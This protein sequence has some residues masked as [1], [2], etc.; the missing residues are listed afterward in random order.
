MPMKASGL[1]SDA[2]VTEWDGGFSWI[3]HPGEGLE[4]SSHAL[5]DGE[6][7]WVVDPVDFDGLDDRLAEA[8]AVAGVVVLFDQH[9]RDAAAVA[10]R[11][12]VPVFV[13]AWLDR[14]AR[15]IDAPVERFDGQLGDTDY[16]AIRIPGLPLWQEAALF[17]GE[18]L[19]VGESVGAGY[20][21]RD[22]EKLGVHPVQSV[23][24]PRKQLRGLDPERVL[25]GHGMGVFVDAGGALAD[26]LAG[27]RRRA[28]GASL[29]WSKRLL[30]G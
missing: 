10:R 5:G 19:V 7:V 25:T 12:D 18:T 14:I 27:A 15:R 3:A 11:H 30:L 1:A 17:D 13:P 29:R 26:A 4:R 28:P 23:L 21:R 20:H 9:G 24:P 8:G 22:G 16:R 2:D 6:D